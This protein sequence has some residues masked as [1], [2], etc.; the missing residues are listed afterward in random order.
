MREI[1]ERK[2]RDRRAVHRL[3]HASDLQLHL[4]AWR[5]W[6]YVRNHEVAAT[7]PHILV[8]FPDNP[9]R[10]LQFRTAPHRA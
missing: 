6:Y 3:Q 4:V 9:H 10:A 8:F 5:T 1:F 2:V 7:I